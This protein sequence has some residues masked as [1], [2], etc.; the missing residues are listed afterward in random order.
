MKILY[1][2]IMEQPTQPD[3]RQRQVHGWKSILNTLALTCGDRLV[4]QS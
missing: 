1:L 2:T 4:L 3:Q